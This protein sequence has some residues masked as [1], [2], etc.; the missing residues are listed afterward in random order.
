M[1]EIVT[2]THVIVDLE[3]RKYIQYLVIDR[4][5]VRTISGKRPG[6]I[7]SLWIATCQFVGSD[8]K[9]TRNFPRAEYSLRIDF[10]HFTRRELVSQ[11]LPEIIPCEYSLM[12][13]GLYRFLIPSNIMT[14]LLNNKKTVAILYIKRFMAVCKSVIS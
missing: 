3:M 5:Q 11:P 14:I 7:R 12:G 8:D 10:C 1:Y 2:S 6:R 13:G 4:Y 9:L